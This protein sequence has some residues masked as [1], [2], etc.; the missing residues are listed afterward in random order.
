MNDVYDN[1]FSENE[2]E[3]QVISS[4][5]L[6]TTSCDVFEFI[7]TEP[8]R[9]RRQNKVNRNKSR[10]E[11][12][13]CTKDSHDMKRYPKGS[14]IVV[15]KEEFEMIQSNDNCDIVHK[16][17][18]DVV[19][20]DCHKT[21]RNQFNEMWLLQNDTKDT[22][23][24]DEHTQVRNLTKMDSMKEITEFDDSFVQ[25]DLEIFDNE[26]NWFSPSEDR[27]IEELISNGCGIFIGDS[28]P[29]CFVVDLCPEEKNENG[30][31]ERI[32]L[33]RKTGAGGSKWLVSI[34]DKK[35]KHAQ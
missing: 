17:N 4:S 3:E 13:S 32:L 12:E 15:P 21:D 24:E 6:P 11:P 1:L 10:P 34:Q 18:I 22:I 31:F 14:F 8:S 27:N 35:L 20:L 28:F 9:Q 25:V 2:E 26:Q 19:H 23:P 29:P 7:S 33:G 30:Q 16:E 5:T